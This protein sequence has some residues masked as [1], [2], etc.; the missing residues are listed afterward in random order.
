[1]PLLACEPT[2]TFLFNPRQG[3]FAILFAKALGATVTAVSH[4]DRKKEDIKKLGASNL[5][6]TGHGADFATPHLRTLDLIICTVN[7]GDMPMS[8]YLSLLRPGGRLVVVGAPEEPISLNVFPLIVHGASLTGSSISQ[9]RGK[10]SIEEML[11]LAATQDIHPWIE[12]RSIK[13]VNRTVVDVS[14]RL[15][16]LP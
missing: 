6:V 10:G 4:S 8:Q 13:D 5:I 15:S 3:H 9:P 11:N 2:R 14:W 1:M 16:T 7:A 12:K